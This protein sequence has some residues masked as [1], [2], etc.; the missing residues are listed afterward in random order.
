MYIKETYKKY[1]IERSQRKQL[2]GKQRKLRRNFLR[3]INTLSEQMWSNFASQFSDSLDENIRLNPLWIDTDRFLIFM[4]TLFHG[5]GFKIYYGS[6]PRLSGVE[7]SN[8]YPLL[9]YDNK[10]AILIENNPTY[11]FADLADIQ[12][13]TPVPIIGL[14]YNS[15][16]TSS[17][18]KGN[19]DAIDSLRRSRS[20]AGALALGHLTVT[21][22]ILKEII[23]L[24]PF[25]QVDQI[26]Q[27]AS[28]IGLTDFLA[29]PIDALPVFGQ[30][31]SV[32]NQLIYSVDQ[33][34][35]DA[36][37]TS[38]TGSE[39]SK[40][41]VTQA[42]PVEALA[43]PHYYFNEL[44]K[45]KLIKA[46]K[47]G[48]ILATFEGTSYNR[49]KIFPFPLNQL[50]YH[51]CLAAREEI[52][53]GA[54]EAF[55][56]AINQGNIQLLS[57]NV[58]LY[59]PVDE[60]DSFAAVS[61]YPA[62][63]IEVKMPLMN[64][65]AEIKLLLYLI[66][67]DPFIKTDWGGEQNDIF[68]GRVMKNGKRLL[69]AFFLKGPSVGGRLTIAKCGKNG[70][71]IQRLFKSPADIFVVQFNG[72]I[73]EMVIEECRQKLTLLRQAGNK[74][75]F[76]TTI[77]GVDTARLLAAYSDKLSKCNREIGW[78]INKL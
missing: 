77:D 38:D 74:Q 14:S 13:K 70:D 46:G 22:E 3:D 67:G 47:H 11:L 62:N 5:L 45:A 7:Q 58:P 10:R 27:I 52:R 71:Q 25:S 44:E 76:F 63:S 72:Q 59:I 26:K 78:R 69:A 32:N 35:K 73:D 9:A 18:A 16:V 61:L 49:F 37:Q 30:Q 29:P 6:L 53:K 55:F 43:D 2:S 54:K 23:L 4:F 34:L 68:S 39:I 57:E 51:T 20:I 50:L 24:N 48:E 42:T 1:D 60:I 65:E 28:R 12:P 19:N 8:R 17:V 64:S 15:V 31:V 56:E 21:L 40:G 66:V 41:D 33:F 36:Q 75:A